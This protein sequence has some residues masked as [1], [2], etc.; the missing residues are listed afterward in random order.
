[1]AFRIEKIKHKNS[2]RA[3]F[4]KLV[5]FCTLRFI[6]KTVLS[7]QK[8]KIEIA[9]NIDA[10]ELTEL[11]MRSKSYW[12]YSS[13]Q[14]SNWKDDL[15]IS[16]KY[17]DQSE[18][19][20]LI[21]KNKLIGYYS[22]FDM[23]DKKVKL[24]NIFLEPEFIGKGYGKLMMDHFFQ[25]IKN[26]DFKSIELDS[27]PNAEKFYQKLGFKII[28]RLESSI[29]NRFLPIMKLDLKPTHNTI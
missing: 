14:I 12:G 2:A 8:M 7:K 20:K 23:G 16:A 21:N 3:K 11:T 28:G 1:M 17:I 15:T 19:F 18:V 22:Y 27:E 29:K 4:E 13:L 26:K 5:S 25:Q 9:K 10:K 24:D 6:H